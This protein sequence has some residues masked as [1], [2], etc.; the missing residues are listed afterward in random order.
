MV[1]DY[2]IYNTIYNTSTIL[3]F[4]LSQLIKF[5]DCNYAML[6]RCTCDSMYKSQNDSQHGLHKYDV[7]QN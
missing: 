5:R 7:N 6:K 2:I 3:L 1:K 4:V